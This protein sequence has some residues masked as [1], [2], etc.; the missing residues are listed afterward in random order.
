MFHW[1]LETLMAYAHQQKLQAASIV[2]CVGSLRKASLR[3]ADATHDARDKELHFDEKLEITSL[4]GTLGLEGG[5]LHMSVANKEGCVFGGHVLPGCQIFTT[6]EIILVHLQ[7][8]TF[9]RRHDPATGFGELVVQRNWP[10]VG[11]GV[12]SGLLLSVLAYLI[13]RKPS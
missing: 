8:L 11:H 3:L 10:R 1:H 2:S 12:V 6:A 13:L 5:H 4:V 7:D 9:S